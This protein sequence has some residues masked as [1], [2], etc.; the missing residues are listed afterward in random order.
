MS[1]TVS[2]MPHAVCW[3]AAPRLIW[4]M[5]VTNLVTFLSYLTIAWT[6]VF[7]VR[8]TR[9]IIAADWAHFGVRFALFI[10]A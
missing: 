6:L 5:V 4:T 3:A 9:R 8:R 1:P 10:L 2:L 7:L